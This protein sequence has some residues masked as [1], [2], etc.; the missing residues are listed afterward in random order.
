MAKYKLSQADLQFC[1]IRASGPGGQHV[2]KVS[3]AVELRFD[4]Q[5]SSLPA[6]VKMKLLR[7]KDQRISKEGVIVLKAQRYRSQEK[8][9]QD[10]VARLVELIDKVTAPNK[11]RIA[12]RPGRAAKERRIRDKKKVGEK[13]ARRGAIK[14]E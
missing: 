11:K 14:N 2:N 12:T 5:S 6:N 7:Y 3:T 9:K 13:K 8:N 4:I 1:A 10:A